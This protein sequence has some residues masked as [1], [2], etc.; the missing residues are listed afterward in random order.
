MAIIFY[1]FY[2]DEGVVAVVVVVDPATVKERCPGQIE[3]R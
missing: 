2:K 1:S 3:S